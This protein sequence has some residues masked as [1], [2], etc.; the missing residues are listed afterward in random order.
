VAD[1]TLP[2]ASS[3]IS[4]DTM[5]VCQ[6]QTDNQDLVWSAVVAAPTSHIHCV[7]SYVC[8]HTC[9]YISKYIHICIF[10]DRL[11]KQTPNILTS[12]S[13]AVIWQMPASVGQARMKANAKIL[14]SLRPF[15]NQH[16]CSASKTQRSPNKSMR[17][18]ASDYGAASCLQSVQK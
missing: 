13:F 11:R 9:K 16:V 7:Y 10:F 5:M 8:T 15:D 4:S 2:Q 17:L 1:V 18:G 12:A 6:A 3:S 14:G